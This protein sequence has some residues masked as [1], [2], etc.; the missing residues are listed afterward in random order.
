LAGEQRQQLALQVL[1]RTEPV[2]ELSARHQVSRK[3]LYHSMFKFFEL[4]NS[5]FAQIE[6]GF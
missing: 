2:T 6:Q 3:F 4:D 1:A 5:R